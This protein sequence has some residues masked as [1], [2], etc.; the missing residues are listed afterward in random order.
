MRLAWADRVQSKT[1]AKS[2]A[3]VSTSRVGRP[4]PHSP[5]RRLAGWSDDTVNPTI[6]PLQELIMAHMDDVTHRPTVTQR[7]WIYVAQFPGRR[8]AAVRRIRAVEKAANGTAA[9]RAMGLARHRRKKRRDPVG[10]APTA[11]PPR[12]RSTAAGPRPT[13]R[14]IP[15]TG[16]SRSPKRSGAAGTLRRNCGESHA[17]NAS[18]RPEPYSASIRG[19]PR[20][21]TWL[22]PLATAAAGRRPRS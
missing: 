6:S 9:R 1:V 7:R 10:A 17:S 8:G 16:L 20:S 2:L 13:G 5:P 4:A 18:R 22:R 14:L 12:S 21:V 15:A 3:P 11:T 19:K